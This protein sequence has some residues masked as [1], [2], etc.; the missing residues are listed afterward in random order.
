MRRAKNAMDRMRKSAGSRMFQSSIGGA[1]LLI[2]HL[3]RSVKL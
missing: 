3:R 1:L 2:G